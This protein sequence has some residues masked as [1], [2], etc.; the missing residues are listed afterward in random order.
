MGNKSSSS[1]APSDDSRVVFLDENVPVADEPKGKQPRGK[2]AR[3][4]LRQTSV[5]VKKAVITNAVVTDVDHM[6]TKDTIEL[7]LLGKDLEAFPDAIGSMASL[8]VL[9]LCKNH[10]TEIPPEIGNVHT[11]TRLL[12]AGNQI[13]SIPAEIGQLGALEDLVLA[14]NPKLSSL[15]DEL[16]SCTNLRVLNL[17]QCRFR[18]I[19]TCVPAVTVRVDEKRAFVPYPGC[20]KVP[21]TFSDL[22]CV[23]CSLCLRLICR[24][25]S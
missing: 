7:I 22:V 23:L 16:S 17:A 18:S 15:P 14:D 19:P 2:R 4:V 10:I 1:S 5:A 12:L 11:L 21:N 6:S 13:T 9:N 20:Q 8:S 3:K 25:T 24:T